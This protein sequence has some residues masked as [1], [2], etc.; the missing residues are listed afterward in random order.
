[1]A[2]FYIDNYGYQENILPKMH[3]HQGHEVTILA[4]TET[5][6]DNK[7]L[8]YVKPSV[9]RTCDDISITRIPYTKIFPHR[10]SKKLRLYKGLFQYLMNNKPDIIFLHDIQF[11]SI[12][13]IAYYAH[14]T[15]V[16]IYADSHT[17]LNNS[18]RNWLSYYVLHKLIYKACAKIIQPYITRFY[19]TL[20]T[21]VDFLSNVYGIPKDMIELLVLGADDSQFDMSQKADI[22]KKIRNDLGFNEK[23]FVIVSGGKIDHRK[24]IHHLIQAFKHISQSNIKLILFGSISDEMSFILDQIDGKTKNIIF[25]SWIKVNKIYEVLFASDLG[26]FPGSHSVLWEQS[27]GIGL[28]C[29]FKKWD[30]IQHVDVGGNC[31]FIDD[32]SPAN[33]R[34]VILYLFNN[35]PVMERMKSVALEKGVPKFSYSTIAMNSI[36]E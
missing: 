25:L 17:D 3:K 2:N 34:D 20:P 18:G 35:N 30:R 4:S 7:K 8:G 24:N 23:D 31:L 29:V 32:V 1:M 13:Q 14:K 12:W 36:R 19:G 26:V 9:Y 28:P 15:K 27:V 16:I 6:Y 21:R 5:Y 33:L 10:L 11:I 22:R